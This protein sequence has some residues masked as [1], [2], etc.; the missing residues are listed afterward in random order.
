MPPIYR[1][2]F[3]NIPPEDVRREAELQT[4]AA[5]ANFAPRV[6]DTDFS[7]FIDM[8]DLREMCIADKYGESLQTM[9]T[10]ILEDIYIILRDLY[11]QYHIEYID[12]T[13]YNFIEKNGR[14]WIIDFGHASKK[15]NN[16]WYLMEVFDAKRIYSWNPDFQ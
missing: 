11:I 9:P 7:S 4:I 1:K 13:P 14:V 10:F 3:Q 2:L 16:N 8:I 12:V 15:G 5:N 6:V